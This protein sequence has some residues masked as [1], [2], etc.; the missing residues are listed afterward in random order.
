M[1]PWITLGVIALY[2]SLLLLIARLTGRHL[3]ARAFFIG[4]GRAPWWVVAI[5][6]VGV[7][8]SGV[9]FISVPGWVRSTGFG[10]LQMV[11]GYIVG[12]IA[13]ALVLLPVYYR[14]RIP[15]IYSYLGERFGRQSQIAGSLIFLLSR[16]ALAS[17]RIYIVAAVL[18]PLTLGPLGCPFICT[19]TTM[20]LMVWIYTQR[21][22]MQ[23]IIWTDL[24]QT[25]VML[26][27]VVMMLWWIQDAMGLTLFQT[28]Q[29]IAD[30]PLGKIF[31]WQDW[32]GGQHFLKQ[33]LSGAFIPIVMTG[34]DQNMMQKNLACRTLPQAQ[35]NMV[36][37]GLCYLPV[38]LLL[39]SLGALIII[40]AQRAGLSLPEKADAIMPYFATEL[41]GIPPI[42][43]RLFIIGIVSAA[44]SSADS[45][46]T[47]LTSSLCFDILRLDLRED[48]R[49]RRIRHGVHAGMAILLVL[50]ALCY[51]VWANGSIIH[52]LFSLVSYLYGPLLGLYTF[53]LF[54]RM[55][56]RGSI[57][58]IAV[59]TPPALCLLSQWLSQRFLGYTMGYE[60]LLMNGAITFAIL[61]IA[62]APSPRNA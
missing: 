61:Y 40:F 47:A 2:F 6:M 39:L 50:L 42:V 49:A 9:S 57:T 60:L 41:E 59:I 19:L 11:M 25:I 31:E 3:P 36:I 27:V 12:Y 43:G 15:S 8:L 24:F 51:R 21:A 34:L 46:L 22:G 10:Y 13:I 33:F 4:N 62:R 38:N 23:A 17:L 54:T 18:H 53:G 14:L 7:S 35:I 58:P 55:Q 20:V 28:V 16:L 44:F 52:L 26:S 5:G 30:S 32:K 45:A 56:Y 29:T 37:N 1:D 48:I